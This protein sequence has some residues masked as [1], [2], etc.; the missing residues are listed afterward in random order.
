M[1]PK[2]TQINGLGISDA[3]IMNGT[4]CIYIFQPLRARND[5]GTIHYGIQG[6]IMG[7]G[8]RADLLARVCGVSCESVTF[9]LVSWVRC[10]T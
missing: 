7:F 1:C 5:F 10:G 9:P 4:T 2:L 6:I 8:E 3:N